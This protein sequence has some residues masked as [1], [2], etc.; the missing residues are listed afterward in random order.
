MCTITTATIAETTTTLISRCSV[1]CIAAGYDW[2]K[3]GPQ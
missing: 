3:E 1:V 2:T